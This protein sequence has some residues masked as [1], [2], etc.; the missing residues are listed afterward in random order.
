MWLKLER[1]SLDIGVIYYPGNTDYDKFLNTLE[2]QLQQRKRALVLGDFNVNLLEKHSKKQTYVTT[3]NAS[4][5]KLLNKISKDYYT[6]RIPTRKSII[7]H[8]C[9]N[10]KDERYHLALVE[11]PLSDHRQIY[12]TLQKQKAPQKQRST[13]Q[14]LNYEK[15]YQTV[16][17]DQNL[18]VDSFEELQE[19]LKKHI[20]NSKIS[21]TKIL[22]LPQEDWIQKD[23][24]E[25]INQKN[26]LWAKLQMEPNN[27]DFEKEYNEK[28]DATAKLIKTT[29]DSYY[30]GQFIN[31]KRKPKKMWNLIGYLSN[32]KL[33]TSPAPPKLIIGS[34]I[35]ND[36]TD[37][38]NAFNLYFST[39]GAQLARNIPQSNPQKS[40][41]KNYPS[42][43]TLPPTTVD[44]VSKIIDNL[45]S[46]SSTEHCLSEDTAI[47]FSTPLVEDLH[48]HS[49]QHLH[50]HVL[51]ALARRDTELRG[52][53]SSSAS[54]DEKESARS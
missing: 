43:S 46:N 3:L 45:D 50:L 26:L 18:S 29:K 39:I 25:S 22:N 4:G 1:Y 8:V 19:S 2:S 30:Y 20:E 9:T 15:L 16:E 42:L 11:S 7:D 33:K 51:I 35:V 23:V 6:R 24:I 44:E 38:C 48:Q 47:Q 53:P 27:E 34:D 49:I 40:R 21:K 54:G 17:K 41:I 13:Y 32:N 10:L 14:S 28:R 36:P 12:L 52:P 31:C 5:Y 37:I